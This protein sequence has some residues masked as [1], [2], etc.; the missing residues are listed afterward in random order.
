[1]KSIIARLFS[2]GIPRDNPMTYNTMYERVLCNGTQ[3]MFIRK[4]VESNSFLSRSTTQIIL[5]LLETAYL[6]EKTDLYNQDQQEQENLW[7]RS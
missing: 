6:R 5:K 1:M 2:W 7:N 4:I 3:V